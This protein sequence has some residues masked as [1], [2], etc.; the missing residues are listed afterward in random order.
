MSLE[1]LVEE[2]SKICELFSHPLRNLVMLLIIAKGEITWT[3]LLKTLR[4]RFGDV[5]PNTLSF[6]LGK[7]TEAELLEK[8]EIG[9]QPRYKIISDKLP[10]VELLIGKK[11]I[12]VA[13]KEFS[14]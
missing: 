9:G 10:E 8:I 12:T 13:K 7:L 3:E 2:R 5:N 11:T 4:K 6:H 14:E 1:E